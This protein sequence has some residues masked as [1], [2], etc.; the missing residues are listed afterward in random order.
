MYE[1][2]GWQV[3]RIFY[4]LP[5]GFTREQRDSFYLCS[6][7]QCLRIVVTVSGLTHLENSNLSPLYLQKMLFVHD[8]NFAILIAETEKADSIQ[9]LLRNK[10]ITREA[11]RS[12]S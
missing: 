2:T 1:G 3:S 9:E 4:F 8:K 10:W 12:E 7:L 6:H 11:E 5:L